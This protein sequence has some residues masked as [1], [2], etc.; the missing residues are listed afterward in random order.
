MAY[1]RPAA[2][3][4]YCKDIRKHYHA[5]KLGCP[6]HNPSFSPIFFLYSCQ[7]IS[8]KAN[9]MEFDFSIGCIPV[10]FPIL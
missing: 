10:N 8:F 2:A 6:E 5:E 7:E 9:D 1:C 4:E 3:W